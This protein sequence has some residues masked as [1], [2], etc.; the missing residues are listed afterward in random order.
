MQQG[1]LEYS[2]ALY[3]KMNKDKAESI[4]NAAGLFRILHGFVL[5][6]TCSVGS[7]AA[8]LLKLTGEF[9]IILSGSVD[10]SCF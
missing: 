3:C 10:P 9:L 8:G 2:M 5:L 1:C 6:A 7:L 4:A